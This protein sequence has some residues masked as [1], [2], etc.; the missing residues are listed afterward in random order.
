MPTCIYLAAKVEEVYL[1][2]DDFCRKLGL[3]PLAVLRTEV[4]AILQL[5]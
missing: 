4:S 2:A 3:E 1:S 5:S